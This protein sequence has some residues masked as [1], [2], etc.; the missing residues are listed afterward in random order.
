L[1]EKVVRKVFEKL[2]GYRPSGTSCVYCGENAHLISDEGSN[3]IYLCVSCW[4]TFTK[5]VTLDAWWKNE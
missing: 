4:R 1:K 2:F 5:G 3:Y